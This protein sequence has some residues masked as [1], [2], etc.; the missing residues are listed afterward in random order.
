MHN[1]AVDIVRDLGNLKVGDS[2]DDGASGKVAHAVGDPFS[3]VD[4]KRG[5]VVGLLHGA[6]DIEA[7]YLHEIRPV[8]AVLQRLEEV[9]GI[10]VCQGVVV[11]LDDLNLVKVL[12]HR[13]LYRTPDVEADNRKNK[14]HTQGD[15][16][17]LYSFF[18]DED[19][20]LSALFELQLVCIKAGIWTDIDIIDSHLKKAVDYVSEKRKRLSDRELELSVI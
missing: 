17:C 9:C 19:A 12:C 20:D 7:G 4:D 15:E 14:G 1:D 2:V 8:V 10:E 11:V 6:C 3:G 5:A 16:E 13:G 18:S